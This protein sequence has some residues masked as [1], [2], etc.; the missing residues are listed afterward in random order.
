MVMAA[1]LASVLKGLAPK[2]DTIA[3]GTPS[4][5][6]PNTPLI[7]SSLGELG[8]HTDQQGFFNNFAKMLM[9]R[10]DADL[11]PNE[12][13]ARMGRRR[14]ASGMATDASESPGESFMRTPTTGG[15]G[16]GLQD[17]AAFI[18][19]FGGHKKQ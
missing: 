13:K 8:A 1:L 3:P 5:S 9:G 18:S 10:G 7:P 6:D 14:D 19:K 16:F 17:I 12:L 15:S 11:T 4:M 2:G